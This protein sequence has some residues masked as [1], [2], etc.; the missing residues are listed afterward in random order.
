[1]ATTT[2]SKSGLSF[3]P[4]G[5]PGVVPAAPIKRPDLVSL[6]TESLRQQILDGVHP[7]GAELPAQGKLAATYN[8]SVNV[9]REALRNLRSLGW[10]RFRR[11]GALRSRA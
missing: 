3:G 2:A 6:V 1:M 5:S 8:V 7:P 11:G 9:I 4:V 10:S